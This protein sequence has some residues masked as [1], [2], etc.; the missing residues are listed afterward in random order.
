MTGGLRYLR[1]AVPPPALHDHVDIH[2]EGG[3]C[4]RYHDPRRFGSLHFTATPETHPLL[5]NIGPEPLGESFTPTYLAGSARG[6]R[7][8]IKCHLMN[9]R[10]VAGVGNIYAN[11]AL[12]RAGIHPARAAG[13]IAAP[14]FV[15]LVAS[16]RDVLTE[17]IAKGGT[18][19]RDFLDS[20]GRPGYFRIDLDVYDR[21]GE[22]CRRCGAAVRLRVLGQR[23]TYY[24][25][26]CQR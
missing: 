25:P 26:R 16:I 1:N 14:R 24:C 6:K 7:I 15:P 12:F 19:L 4:L 3:D 10:V 13:R 5:A 18:T 9:S 2:F 21:A 20:D 22:A 11:E 17:A 8:A 23:S